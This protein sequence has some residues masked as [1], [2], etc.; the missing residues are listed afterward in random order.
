[1]KLPPSYDVAIRAGQ[2][3][4][5]RV[6]APGSEGTDVEIAVGTFLFWIVALDDRIRDLNKAEH[7]DAVM[8]QSASSVMP[9]LHLAR[10]ALAHGVVPVSLPGG[11][12]VAF[13]IPFVIHPLRWATLSQL[14]DGWT[15]QKSK[16]LLRQILVFEEQLAERETVP[17]LQSALDWVASFA[18]ERRSQFE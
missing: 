2:N 11:I 5:D 18:P 1:M 13:T 8:T 16:H 6:T 15:P 10:N 9:G 7:A 17:T 3:A 14:T 4:L 12:T